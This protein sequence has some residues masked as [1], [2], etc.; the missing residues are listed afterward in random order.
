MRSIVLR[1]ALAGVCLAATTGWAAA[2]AVP[3]PRLDTPPKEEQPKDP[4]KEQPPKEDPPQDPVPPKVIPG[5]P[6]PPATAIVPSHPLQAAA[7][8]G[9][10]KGL[11]VMHLKPAEGEVL[12]AMI[13]G[14]NSSLASLASTYGN[15]GSQGTPPSLA[16]D[17]KAKTIFIR[18][19]AEQIAK[20]EAVLAA[21]D[22]PREEW[23]ATDL[24]GTFVLPVQHTTIQRIGQVLSRLRMNVATLAIGKAGGL[25]VYKGGDA[26]A[27]TQLEEVV[28]ILDTPEE[29]APPKMNPAVPNPPVPNPPVP[30]PPTPSPPKLIPP[31]Q[32]PKPAP[33][34]PKAKPE[35]KPKE[36][37][38]KSEEPKPAK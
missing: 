37:K 26:E 17:E 1:I 14:S 22:K 27:N 16:A 38:P 25:L 9:I 4:P 6:M 12:L 36:E 11:R 5:G 32:L 8:P 31:D 3:L 2:Q 19:T 21:F 34:E 7:T 18:G 24:K 33:T 28:K 23:E 15:A 20:A 30:E 13:M 10:L 35:E 29:K